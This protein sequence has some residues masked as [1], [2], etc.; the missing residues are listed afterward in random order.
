MGTFNAGDHVVVKTLNKRGIIQGALANGKYRVAI[1]ALAMTCAE[2]DL[3]ATTAPA[4]KTEYP[5][6]LGK[7]RPPIPPHSLD[8]HGMTVDEALRALDAWLDRAIL[9]NLSHVKAV[10]GLGTG[11]LQS[12]VHAHLTQLTAVK[13]FKINEWN[14]GETDIYL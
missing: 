10:H 14:P 12:A 13:H 1:G 6:H 4:P 7:P 9:A 5:P 3:S 11:R 2:R 8:L